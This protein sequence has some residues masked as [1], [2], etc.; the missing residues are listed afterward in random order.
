[1]RDLYLKISLVIN[2]NMIIRRSELRLSNPTTLAIAILLF[3][4]IL[5]VSCF[6]SKIRRK[7][8]TPFKFLKFFKSFTPTYRSHL[9]LI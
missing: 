7:V 3:F 1:M 5:L 2:P 9:L 4:E 8:L 6:L